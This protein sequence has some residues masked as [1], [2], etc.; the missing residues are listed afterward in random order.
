M[1]FN[2]YLYYNKTYKYLK[3][4]QKVVSFINIHYLL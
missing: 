4:Y 1:Y 2:Y 3:Y